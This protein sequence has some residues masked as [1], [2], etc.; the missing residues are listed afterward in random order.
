[1][2]F[3]WGGADTGDILRLE[4]AR[5][6][7][8]HLQP[9]FWQLMGKNWNIWGLVGHLSPCVHSV[10]VAW[11]SL[12][13]GCPQVIEFLTWGLLFDP[14]AYI[15]IEQDWSCK[16][17]YN[18]TL[19]FTQHPTLLITQGIPIFNVCRATQDVS[20]QR[21]G[22]FHRMTLETTR[23]FLH[24]HLKVK[25]ALLIFPNLLFR[26]CPFWFLLCPQILFRIL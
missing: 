8:K 16:A 25:C 9:Y 6:P 26:F 2:Q 18:L 7:R 23:M 5:N 17:S 24:D 15:P 11:D 12:P 14:R 1:M 4:R 20:T 3:Q 19:E 21:Y 22:S 10:W 13:Y